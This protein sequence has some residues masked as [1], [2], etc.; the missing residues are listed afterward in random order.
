MCVCGGGGHLFVVRL[1]HLVL[2]LLS[3]PAELLLIFCLFQLVPQNRQV[4]LIWG[5]E[6]KGG[7]GR[8]GEG[9]GG[10]SNDAHIHSIHVWLHSSPCD[11]TF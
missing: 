2:D 9:R 4:R 3:N 1:V 11:L 6:E 10:E 5:G 8:G 7:E